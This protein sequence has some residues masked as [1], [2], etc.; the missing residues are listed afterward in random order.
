K[1]VFAGSLVVG[2]RPLLTIQIIEALN[3]K[4]FE[5]ELHMFGDGALMPDLKNYVLENQLESCVFLNGSRDIGEVK[6]AL[7]NAHFNILPS[8]SEGWPKAVAEGMFFGAIPISTRISCLEWMLDN[9][10]RGILIEPDL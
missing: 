1:F 8:K 9:E 6:E 4:G 2:K 5:S 10:N 7:I 3:K